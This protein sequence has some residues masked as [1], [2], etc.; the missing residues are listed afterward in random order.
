MRVLESCQ[1]VVL[2]MVLVL[3]LKTY[4]SGSPLK[5]FGAGKS[6]TDDINDRDCIDVD[7]STHCGRR[8]CGTVVAWE[9]EV[10][11]ADSDGV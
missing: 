5:S 6:L 10:E 1:N 4:K 11:M 9:N 2:V 8:S 3:V 7:G